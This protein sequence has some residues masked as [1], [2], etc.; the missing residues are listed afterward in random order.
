M[1][2]KKHARAAVPPRKSF[3]PLLIIFGAAVIAFGGGLVLYRSMSDTG[4][5]ANSSSAVAPRGATPP[6]A[7][8]S[9]AAPIIIEEF[10]DFQ[11]PP[12]AALH[13]ELVL[14]EQEYGDRLRIIFRQLPLPIHRNAR[15]AA[16]AA[17][18]AAMQN[19]F[20]E[21]HDRLFENQTAWA[22]MPNPRETFI[23]YARE[24]GLNTEAFVR[25]MDS[26]AVA[27][28]LASDE[29]R[30]NH[31]GVMGTPGIFINNRQ[32]YSRE[33]AAA[34]GLRPIIATMLNNNR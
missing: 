23:G 21:M 34:G 26:P 20:W 16:R 15:D 18:A 27:E 9:D 11:C 17:E 30:A 6:H 10:A 28:R 12:C 29:Q 19:H 7:R 3:A 4:S 32:M 13:A 2:N 8:G 22:E 25:D 24:L 31:L 33:I 1:S 5:R 14:T